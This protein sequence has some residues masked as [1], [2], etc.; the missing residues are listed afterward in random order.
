MTREEVVEI[1][2]Y[3]KEHKVIYKSRLEE[4]NIPVWRF[5]DSKSR[6]AAEQSSGKSAQGEFIELPHS[7]FFV[8]VPSFA[9]TTGRK[10]KSIPATPSGLKETE[11]RTSA[12]V[13][14]RICGELATQVIHYIGKLYKIE[15]EANDAGLA[16]EERKEKRISEAYPLILEFEKWLQDAYLRVLPKSRMGKAIEYTYRNLD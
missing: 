16:T 14:I 4:L 8:P 7:G 12:G 9:G 5:Y 15:S 1:M 13:A 3:C 10:Q 6:Y 2:N 11:I